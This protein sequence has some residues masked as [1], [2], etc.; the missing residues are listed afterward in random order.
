MSYLL[1]IERVRR[2]ILMDNEQPR[3]VLISSAL[4]HAV[5][6]E[7]EPMMA[8]RF[9]AEKEFLMG[10]KIEWT[11]ASALTKP[12]ISIRTT[13]GDTRVVTIIGP[14][15]DRAKPTTKER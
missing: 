6:R 10:M 4:R 15:D 8:Y 12:Q 5:L 14:S 7:V 11:K 3:D 13:R 9:D 1:A 2:Q